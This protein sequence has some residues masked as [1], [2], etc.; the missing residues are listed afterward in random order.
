MPAVLGP[1]W[2]LRET[3]P[4]RSSR[5]PMPRRKLMPQV[6]PSGSNEI[7]F[8]GIRISAVQPSSSM[9]AAA[10]QMPCHSHSVSVTF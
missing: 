9:L 6:S 5:R 3:Q 2:R 1:V 7:V 10:Y 4:M 8:S